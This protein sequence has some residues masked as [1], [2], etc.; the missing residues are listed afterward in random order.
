[1]ETPP[2]AILLKP[3][4]RLRRSPSPRMQDNGTDTIPQPGPSS[5]R[6]HFASIPDDDDEVPTPRISAKAIASPNG[7]PAPTSFPDL[8]TA[9]AIPADTPAARLRAL[10]AREPRSPRNAA[11]TA[12]QI[13]PS[14][15]DS[16]DDFPRFGSDTSSLARDNLKSIFSRALREPGDTPQKGRPRRNSVDSSQVEITPVLD[17]ER[18]KHKGK[19][20]SMSDEEAEKPR[21]T[22]ESDSSFRLSQAATFDTLRARLMSSQS[23]LMDQNLP[24]ALY[25]PSTSTSTPDHHPHAPSML[26]Q[27]NPSPG[28]PSVATGSPRQSFQ[29]PSQL[30]FQSKQDSE[31]QQAIGNVLN[32]EY[33]ASTST[34]DFTQMDMVPGASRPPPSLG[35]SRHQLETNSR[36]ASREFILPKASSSLSG[37]NGADGECCWIHPRYNPVYILTIQGKEHHS[38]HQR[39]REWNRPKPQS[40]SGTPDIYHSHSQESHRRHSQELPSPPHVKSP[41]HESVMSSSGSPRAMHGQLERRGSLASLRSFD[42][43]HILPFLLF[44]ILK[45]VS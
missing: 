24:T 6:I 43:F 40:R 36:R 19:R 25:D 17:R 13:P 41:T 34:P 39:E 45:H 3:R 4:L 42:V 22:R 38:N 26:L 32:S 1:M 31:M 21:S 23:Q 16:S 9:T 11:S 20:R 7:D 14:E 8:N 35:R 30:A 27:L 28:T 44:F 10:L 37:L 12:P 33:E 15:V 2:P 29:M 18:A 5:T